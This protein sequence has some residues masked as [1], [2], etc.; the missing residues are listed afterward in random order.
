MKLI[1]FNLTGSGQPREGSA[2]QGKMTGSESTNSLQGKFITGGSVR[3][4]DQIIEEVD[5]QQTIT[6]MAGKPP[7]P[8]P[9]AQSLFMSGPP[10]P[11]APLPVPPGRVTST[12]LS[13]SAPA[14]RA[15]VS[16]TAQISP[17]RSSATYTEVLSVRSAPGMND[18]SSGLGSGS[19]VGGGD[20][21][22]I[23]SNTDSSEDE[24]TKLK[25]TRLRERIKYAR[26]VSAQQNIGDDVDAGGEN[27]LLLMDV[28]QSRTSFHAKSPRS[29][30]YSDHPDS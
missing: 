13:S 5:E 26:S 8:R 14:G 23:G 24:F 25:K 7:E 12:H 2:G 19:L 6:S 3:I 17:T 20:N 10:P 29:S 16:P 28:G 15:A 21:I 27:Q 22:S 1:T 18:N 9:T 11:S 4:A 30:T